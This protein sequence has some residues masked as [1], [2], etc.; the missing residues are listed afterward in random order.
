[1]DKSVTKRK[2]YWFHKPNEEHPDI[3]IPRDLY[4]VKTCDL[5][6]FL[7]YKGE[8][9][10][11]FDDRYHGYRLVKFN[12][13]IKELMV[14]VSTVS[15]T[16]YFH[17]IMLLMGKLLVHKTEALTFKFMYIDDV[18][19][20]T[21]WYPRGNLPITIKTLGFSGCKI[22]SEFLDFFTKSNK[23]GGIGYNL[24]TIE[25]S[26]CCVT[27]DNV[28]TMCNNL[29][30]NYVLHYV[31]RRNIS[32]NESILNEQLHAIFSE[33]NSWSKIDNLF[34]EIDDYMKRNRDGYEKC[35]RSTLLPLL[36]HRFSSGSIFS[37]L[38]VDVTRLIAK[39]IWNSRGTKVWC[40]GIDL[41]FLEGDLEEFLVDKEEPEK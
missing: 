37:V 30:T 13:Q 22:G 3:T 31:I 28:D 12:C 24:T 35:R 39:K 8:E 6:A 19:N 15:N 26:D 14:H 27:H 23:D 21:G 5:D 11:N 2:H 1:M 9:V 33:K 34:I 16:I 20:V 18:T 36:A 40:Y 41:D 32:E 10:V 29:K 4:V 17:N 25:F 7:E 38:G